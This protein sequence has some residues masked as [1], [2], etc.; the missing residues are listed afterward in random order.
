M[1]FKYSARTKTGEMQVGNIEAVNREAAL[2]TLNSHDLYVLSLEGEAPAVWYNR[3]L[4]IFNRVK[5]SELM[6]FTRQ[7]ATMLD[8]SIPLNDA[9]KSLYRQTRNP[10]L[11]EAVF[12]ISSDI[13]SGLSLSQAL[14][15]QAHIFS[16]FY[17][18][19]I[20]SAEVTG[21]VEAAANFLADYL[22]KEQALVSKIRNAMIYPTFVIV[23]FVITSA[24]LIGVVFP[25]LEPVFTE[26]QVELPLISQIFL[27]MG[28]FVA[29]WWLIIIIVAIIIIV[30]LIDYFRSDEGRVVWDQLVMSLPV[31]GKLLR[32]SYVARFAEATSV[33]IKGGI[34]IAQAIEVGS[35]TIGSF[36][37]QDVLKDVANRVRRGELLSQALESN[38]E[39]FPPLVSQMV[40]IGEKTGRLEPMLSKVYDFYS[41]E[42]NNLVENLVELIQPILILIIGAFVG[43]LFASILLPIYNLVQVF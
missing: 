14:E 35:H 19:L 27:G 37:Y 21:E 18:N 36:I 42:I 15:R 2:A 29:S 17:I 4:S 6:I 25:Q 12:D 43:L 10:I 7:F 22:E 1:K 20:K 23:L 28:N 3:L 8:A 34:P 13:D 40:A 24:V 16:E 38:D 9:L 30:L 32:Q 11:K 41:R 31:F 26:A 5:R 33:L 39:Y